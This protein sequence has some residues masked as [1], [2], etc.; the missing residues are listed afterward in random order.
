M[1][2]MHNL[3]FTYDSDST[4]KKWILVFKTEISEI[5]RVHWSKVWPY[6]VASPGLY[7]AQCGIQSPNTVSKPVVRI[8]PYIIRY[9]NFITC[10]SKIFR[11]S[12]DILC[13][14]FQS[15][16]FLFRGHNQRLEFLG[17]TV[18]QLVASDYLFKHFPDHHEGHLSVSN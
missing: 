16:C 9:I 2:I 11:V 13:H 14:V 3:L 15:V 12:R 10:I 18:L 17:D 8:C 7:P 6:S 4:K 5:W 1:Y